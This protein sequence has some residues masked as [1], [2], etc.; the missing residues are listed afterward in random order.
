LQ[1]EAKKGHVI[2]SETIKELLAQSFWK[3]LAAC[4]SNE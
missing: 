3:K 4:Q 2:T 1:S